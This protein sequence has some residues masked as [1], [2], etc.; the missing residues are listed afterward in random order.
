MADGGGET[1]EI[2]TA[3]R[4][5]S[6]GD[7]DSGVDGGCKAGEIRLAIGHPGIFAIS[8]RRDRVG[9]WCYLKRL[10]A[11]Q[12]GLVVVTYTVSER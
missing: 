7:Q 12:S 2:Q 9:R 8:D 10:L 6:G 5:G 4:G 1:L 3:K 11:V